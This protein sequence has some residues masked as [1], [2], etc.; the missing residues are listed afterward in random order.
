MTFQIDLREPVSPNGARSGGVNFNVE[1]SI[2]SWQTAAT[3][4][5]V[6]TLEETTATETT[7]VLMNNGEN[8]IDTPLF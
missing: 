8:M 6:A 1:D 2:G 4:P 5:P 3:I 7:V